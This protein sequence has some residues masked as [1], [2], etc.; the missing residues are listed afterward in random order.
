MPRSFRPV[1]RARFDHVRIDCPL[2]QEVGKSHRF[3]LLLE[4]ADKGIADDLPLY[5]GF[6]HPFQSAQ[7]F[8][9]SIDHVQLETQVSGESLLDLAALPF[10]Q[11]PGIDKD[12]RELVSDRAINQRGR[13]AR[14]QPLR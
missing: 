8:I 13:H 1:R 3:G 2:D 4:D 9:H 7:G 6:E 11:Q 12:R 10:P 14:N 5:L